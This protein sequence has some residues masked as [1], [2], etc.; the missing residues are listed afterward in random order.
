MRVSLRMVLLYVC[1]NWVRNSRQPHNG[2]AYSKP[3]CLIL[4]RWCSSRY[5][6]LKLV[7][8]KIRTLC[9]FGQNCMNIVEPRHLSFF[10]MDLESIWSAWIGFETNYAWWTTMC[11]VLFHIQLMVSIADF[12]SHLVI[13]QCF[14]FLRHS[15]NAYAQ[16][17]A[18]GSISNCTKAQQDTPSSSD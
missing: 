9:V 1:V 3:K 13:S 11:K 4:T 8:Q 2:I 18:C 16:L 15:Y 5:K 17:T 6:W 14:S 12:N 7:R 10:H